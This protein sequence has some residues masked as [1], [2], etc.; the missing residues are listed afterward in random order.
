MKIP[1]VT[2]VVKSSQVTFQRISDDPQLGH[3]VWYATDVT[4]DD[5]TGL[6]CW[7]FPV[8]V[9]ETVGATFLPTDKPMFFMR[10][11]RRQVILLNDLARVQ[12]AWEQNLE[13]A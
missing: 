13:D 1:R 4:L 8:P 12:T 6:P 3:N 10:W 2:E 11:I 7:E 9:H 5:G